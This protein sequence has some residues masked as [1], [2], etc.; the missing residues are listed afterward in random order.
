MVRQRPRRLVAVC[1][2]VPV[3]Q[4]SHLMAVPAGRSDLALLLVHLCLGY[5]LTLRAALSH[6]AISILILVPIDWKH[7]ILPDL[8]TLLGIAVGLLMSLQTREPG[9]VD[10]MLGTAVGGLAPFM[11]RALYM[12][13]VKARS[14]MATAGPPNLPGRMARRRSR[15]LKE[16]ATERRAA[17]EWVWAT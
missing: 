15:H 1:W 4:R 16:F 9:M 14:R 8:I 7:G 13:Y 5:G 6:S 10:S 12:T 11:I 3:V 2:P 17:K